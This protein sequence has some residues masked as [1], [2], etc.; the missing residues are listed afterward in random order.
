MGYFVGATVVTPPPP[1][2]NPLAVAPGDAPIQSALTL[3]TKP[4]RVIY[5]TWIPP[6]FL[7]L[8]PALPRAHLPPPPVAPAMVATPPLALP[9][10][11]LPPAP[12]VVTLTLP[13]AE[14]PMRAP[15]PPPPVFL[16]PARAG[17]IPLARLVNR[18]LTGLELRP[19]IT[20]PKSSLAGALH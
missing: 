7:S 16:N 3:H 18:H 20:G 11:N 9:R 5:R 15:V 4:P 10:P 2:P 6:R 8:P 17:L 14:I 19:A 13:G 1:P 12:A